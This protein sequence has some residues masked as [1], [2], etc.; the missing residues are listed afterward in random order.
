MEFSLKKHVTPTG[1]V[2][3]ACLVLLLVLGLGLRQLASESAI[4]GFLESPGGVLIALAGAWLAFT[5]A[6]VVLT[7]LGYPC[8]S[9]EARRNV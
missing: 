2:L 4:G 1:L 8:V 3:A 7:M 6:Y 5:V 9:S